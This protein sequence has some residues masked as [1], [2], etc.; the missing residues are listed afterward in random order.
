MRQPRRPPPRRVRRYAC[1]GQRGISHG[2]FGQ[3]KAL[4]S[5]IA[6]LMASP[7]G[8][9]AAVIRGQAATIQPG[10]H[11]DLRQDGRDLYHLAAGMTNL[12]SDGPNH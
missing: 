7:A 11:L 9:R 8:A 10:R 4:V 2:E 1:P 5:V 3:F 6:S 12:S